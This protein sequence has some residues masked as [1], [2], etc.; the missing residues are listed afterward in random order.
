MQEKFLIAKI[1][2]HKASAGYKTKI[3]GMSKS[4]SNFLKY[5]IDPI[6]HRLSA[7]SVSYIKNFFSTLRKKMSIF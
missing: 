7:K 1:F 5:F 3:F 2:V 6:L 4:S